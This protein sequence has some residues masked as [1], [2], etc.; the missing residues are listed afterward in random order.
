MRWLVCYWLDGT[1][2]LDWVLVAWGGMEGPTLAGA[3]TGAPPLDFEGRQA[4]KSGGW[5]QLRRRCKGVE[6]LCRSSKTIK[7]DYTQIRTN[8]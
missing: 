6:Y 3:G 5:H 7:I 1:N 2:G 4:V 8:M